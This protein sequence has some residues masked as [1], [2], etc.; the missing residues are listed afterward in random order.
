MTLI[1]DSGGLSALVRQPA[2]LAEL[3]RRGLWPAQLPA[4]VLAESLTGDPRRD[5]A[6]NR[7]LRACH[8]RDVDE[9]MAREAARLRTAARRTATVSATDALVAALASTLP[10][11]IVLT[12]DPHDL[13]AL[14]GQTARPITI[15]GV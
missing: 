7:L 6:T 8:V 12:S 3:A 9:P 10:A 15:A 14:A 2:R 4:V 1:L 5:H 11:P 13:A